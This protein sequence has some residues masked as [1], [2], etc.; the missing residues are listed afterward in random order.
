MNQY[1]L[2]TGGA[3]FIGSH[4]VD[5]LISKGEK[6]IVV[7]DLSTGELNNIRFKEKIIFIQGNISHHETVNNL[8]AEYK[9]TKIFHHAAVASVQKSIESPLETHSV[10]QYSTLLLL[11]AARK[12]KFFERFV[13]ASSAAI[14]GNQS[15]LPVSE[16][17]SVNPL[18]PYAIDKY[19]SEQY[20]LAYYR[21]YGVPTVVLRYFNVY[22]PR[23]NGNSPYSGV[24]SILSD[25][26]L[27]SISGEDPT[28][29]IYGDGE[30][31]RDFIYVQDVVQANILVASKTEAI[32][33]VFNVGSGKQTSLNQLISI[34]HNI[35][36]S[37]IHV[38]YCSERKGDIKHSCANIARLEKL[39]FKLKY[40][41]QDGLYEYWSELRKGER[42]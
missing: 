3:G 42:F 4:L 21:M 40:S 31:T 15:T 29:N 37:N 16:S 17:F 25:R 2:V 24:I 7:D 1:T 34:Y 11:E 6:V 35:T 9:I 39:G 41:I 26:F 23:Q 20:A 18:S 12:Q 14:Y 32:G 36:G 30:Q 8:F 5:A 13:Y 19:A 38:R 28:F 10:N 22:G 27:K 33:Q